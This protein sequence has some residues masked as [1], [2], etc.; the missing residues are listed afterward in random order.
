[1]NTILVIDD[2][3]MDLQLMN[4]FFTREGFQVVKTADGPQGVDLYKKLHPSFVF[5]DLGLPSMNGLDVLREIRGIDEEA[6]VIVI[7]G[8]GSEKLSTEAIRLGALGFVEKTWD[9]GSMMYE[10][11]TALNAFR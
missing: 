5:L 9:I 2:D 6:R 3:E 1:M 8:Y 4:L 10:I 7:T 11:K